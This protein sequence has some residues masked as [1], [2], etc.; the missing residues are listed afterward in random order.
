M[1]SSEKSTIIN[2]ILLKISAYPTFGLALILTFSPEPRTTLGRV[3]RVPPWVLRVNRFKSGISRIP[4]WPRWVKSPRRGPLCEYR[5]AD[6]L[7]YSFA[8]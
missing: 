2:D 3:F 6:M 8:P 1:L 4:R 5:P 7:W